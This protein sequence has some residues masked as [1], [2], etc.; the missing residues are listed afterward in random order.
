MKV[1]KKRMAASVKFG[2]FLLGSLAVLA[3]GCSNGAGQN[4]SSGLS[5]P[6][7]SPTQT[8]IGVPPVSRNNLVLTING[9]GTVT[10]TDGAIN[11]PG[12]CTAAYDPTA[13]VTLTATPGAGW[14]FSGWSGDASCASS[15]F[16][17]D[18]HTACT[19]VFLI[20]QQLVDNDSPFGFLDVPPDN[21]TYYHDLGISWLRGGR[22]ATDWADVEKTQGTYDFS[23]MDTELCNLASENLGLIYVMRPIN[24]L[25]NT[26]WVEGD[27][28][29]SHE[30]PDGHVA[31]YANFIKA[32]VERYDGDGVDDAACSTPIRIKHY[33]FVHELSPEAAGYW[34]NHT[35]QYAE[36]FGAMYGAMLE[37][38]SDC[39]LYMP[40]PILSEL[41]SSPNFMTDVLNSLLN[42]GMSNVGFDYHDFSEDTSQQP[43]SYVTKG[44]DYTNHGL[45][46]DKIKSIT[47]QYGFPSDNVISAESGMAGTSAMEQDQAGYV[48]R[49]YVNSLSRGQKKILWTT[50]LE[51]SQYPDTS[52][53]AHTGVIHNPANAEN[54]S[55]KKLAYYTY[56]KMVETLG[57]SDWTSTSILQESGDINIYKFMKNGAPLYVAWWDF[58][59]DP[60]YSS[61]NTKQISLTGLS[62]TTA[63][64]TVSVPNGAAGSDVTNYATAFPV[65]SAPVT[66][67]TLSVTLGQYPVYIEAQ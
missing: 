61:G 18:A 38:C 37:A 64:V 30:Y 20:Q 53:F 40:V 4:T 49:M 24:A 50:T 10:S 51:Y 58:F 59:N 16:T 42:R 65:S 67:G 28:S 13:L 6:V 47:Q 62:G 56:K 11:C 22:E 66:N 17:M 52:I 8:T 33:Q 5:G 39:I 3:H 36:V 60:A 48:V 23:A 57:G 44:E 21:L 63:K 19:A 1:V 41:N 14:Y 12:T 34:R 43:P 31:D 55:S 29:Q 7:S 46:M 15:A 25:Y 32:W 27:P 35:D 45:Y 2:F 54:L 26:T 9:Q